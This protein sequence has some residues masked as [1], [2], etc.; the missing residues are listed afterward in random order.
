MISIITVPVY[1]EGTE[2]TEV[3][4]LAQLLSGRARI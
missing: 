3:R 2:V 4:E 1:D